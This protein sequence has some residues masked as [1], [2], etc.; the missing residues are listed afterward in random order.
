MIDVGWL[1]VH[2]LLGSLGGAA[3]FALMSVIPAGRWSW[4]LFTV[5]MAGS[6]VVGF[7]V[8]AFSID[9]LGWTQTASVLAFAAGFT[10]F[11]ALTLA[12]AEWVD[13]GELRR[14]LGLVASQVVAGALLA[15]LGY[16]SAVAVVGAW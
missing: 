2:V 4:G 16:I 8:G 11:S 6:V 13:R 12:G 15:A 14:G 10:T 3:R 5:N 7:A 9:A 1:A